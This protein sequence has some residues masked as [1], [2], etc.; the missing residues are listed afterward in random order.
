MQA[1]STPQDNPDFSAIEKA[2]GQNPNAIRAIVGLGQL[3]TLTSMSDEE[4]ARFI[5]DDR[6]QVTLKAYGI[7][8]KEKLAE[9]VKDGAAVDQLAL[10]IADTL[11]TT[12]PELDVDWARL[13]REEL[14]NIALDL[15]ANN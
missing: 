10:R 15:E 5:S 2:V 4:R 6:R 11:I 9:F 14:D 7:D 1:P 8:S 3:R 13:S 12:V